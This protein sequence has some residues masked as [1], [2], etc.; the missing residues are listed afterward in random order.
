MRLYQAAT[1]QLIPSFS[2]QGVA[3]SD[4]L[5]GENGEPVSL[6]FLLSSVIT[7]N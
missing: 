1:N 6:D 2:L 4:G 7:K 5:P 3:G